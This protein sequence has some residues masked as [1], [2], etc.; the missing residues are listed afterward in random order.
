MSLQTGSLAQLAAAYKAPE[1]VVAAIQN[2]SQRTGV[3]F[4]YLLTKAQ[5]ESS[6]NPDAKASSSSATGLYQF[7][8]KT[9]LEMVRDHGQDC[10][11][12]QYASAINNDCQVSSSATRTQ[13]LNLRKDPS[14]SAYMAAEYTKINQQQLEANTD[15]KV[16][17]TELYLAHFLGAGGASKFLNAYESNP[18]TKA[19]HILPTEAA[20]NP[21]VFYNSDGTA[22]SLKQIY[23]H[24]ASKFN[25]ASPVVDA[26]A[27]QTLPMSP[28]L[29]ANTLNQSMSQSSAIAQLG[30]INISLSNATCNGLLDSANNNTQAA[31]VLGIS[32]T[33]LNSLQQQSGQQNLAFLTQMALDAM[34]QT[35]TSLTLKQRGV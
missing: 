27:S 7:T 29:A 31:A 24:F 34:A 12:G 32:P 6:F 28:A 1:T 26:Q 2:A 16:G 10:G 8:D 18:N 30:N 17:K 21:G 33:A 9:W 14:I 5:T 4:G 13:I 22:L 35:N 15:A 3:D 19:A 25:E 20:S 23:N 11:I